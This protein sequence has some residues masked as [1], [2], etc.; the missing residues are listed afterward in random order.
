MCNLPAKAIVIRKETSPNRGKV[1][2]TCA[3]K[4][5]SCFYKL[6]HEVVAERQQLEHIH[7]LRPNMDQ[8]Q[9]AQEV[10]KMGSLI[11]QVKSYK[12]KAK[13]VHDEVYA[14]GLARIPG[15]VSVPETSA[16]GPWHPTLQQKRV[17]IERFSSA[18]RVRGFEVEDAGFWE[19]TYHHLDVILHKGHYRQEE[20]YC[21]VIAADENEVTWLPISWLHITDPGPI[22][23]PSSRASVIAV[24][25][26]DSTVVVLNRKLL[27]LYLDPLLRTDEKIP[28]PFDTTGTSRVMFITQTAKQLQTCSACVEV[29]RPAAGVP[30]LSPSQ[31]VGLPH[32]ASHNLL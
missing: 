13:I 31:D 11:A 4:G 2:Y 18:A 29:W 10:W 19:R 26:G 23:S 6:H 15:A 24:V 5:L 12:Y 7:K 17:A 1:Y 25:F 3:S 28:D 8:H 32:S 20:F 16:P 30:A 21:H 9:M 14:A 27:C 22:L